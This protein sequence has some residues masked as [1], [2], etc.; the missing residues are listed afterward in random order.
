MNQEP[1][2]L[3]KD[4]GD[5][6]MFTRLGDEFGSRILDGLQFVDFAI[7]ESGQNAIAIF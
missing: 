7:R 1:M 2:E 3:L 4:G 6:V 5:M